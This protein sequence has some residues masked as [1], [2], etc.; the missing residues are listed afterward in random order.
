VT[1]EAARLATPAVPRP[2]ARRW[3][4]GMAQL[5][6]SPTGTI[7]LLLVLLWVVAAL[8]APWIATHSPTANN[9]AALA[10]PRPS[11]QHFLG[12]DMLGRDL[13]SRIL[14]GA[15]TVLTV[16]PIAT[17]GALALGALFGLLAGYRG[18]LADIIVSRVCDIL[19]SFPV[20]IL[21]LIV[22]VNFGPSMFNIIAV[23]TIT[24]APIIA[25]IVRGVALE[26]RGREYVQAARLRGESAWYIMF[27]EILPNARGPLIV[28]ACLRMGYTTV[29]IGSLGFLGVGLPPPTPD[30]GGM[31]R[32][33]YGLL[34]VHPHMALFPAAAISSLVIGFNLLAMGLRETS[35]RD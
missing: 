4:S 7:G 1:T 6:Y 33:S 20:I 26:L 2:R 13:Y 12:T 19:L 24:K 10:N 18:G 11:A 16:A 28:E 29:A 8:L 23:I 22:I 17:G 3:L 32:E 15:R 31:V 21:Y 27:V 35:L 14:F 9:Y 30:W 5:A 25:R 34:T